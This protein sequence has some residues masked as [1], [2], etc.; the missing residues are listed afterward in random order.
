[1]T[2]ILRIRTSWTGLQGAPYLSTHYFTRVDA[3]SAGYAADA[4]DAFF[5]AMAGQIDNN[6]TWNVEGF[7]AVIDDSTGALV[8]ID[9]LSGGVSG[10]GTDS[11]Q[12]APFATQGLM[13]LYTGTVVGGRALRGRFFIPG[14]TE[15]NSNEGVPSG[16]YLSAAASGMT[17]LLTS[18]DAEL[19][20]W[21]RVHLTSAVVTSGDLWRQWAVLRSRR[22]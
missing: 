7:V 5:T 15:N 10:A 21:S 1:M 22:D 18:P 16:D 12:S 2:D 11:G 19:R 8:G 14:V 17:A 6:L 20:V 3:D 13:R 9:N 4:V